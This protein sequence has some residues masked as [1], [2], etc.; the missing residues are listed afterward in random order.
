MV[1]AGVFIVICTSV[2]FKSYQP[3][4]GLTVNDVNTAYDISYG[5]PE[6]ALNEE[7]TETL[8]ALLNEVV[9]RKTLVPKDNREGGDLGFRIEY[10]DGTSVEISN[11]QPYFYI[12]GN[13]YIIV[14]RSADGIEDFEIELRTILFDIDE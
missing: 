12:N 3:F 10:T 14:N 9:L 13:I 7:Q 8:V 5:Y 2:F 11:V 1:I 6:Y 4:N